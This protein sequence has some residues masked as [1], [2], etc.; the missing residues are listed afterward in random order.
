IPGKSYVFKLAKTNSEGRFFFSIAEGYN[1][2]NSTIQ[3]NGPQE[4]NTQYKIVLDNKALQIG[5][6]DLSAIKLDPNIRDWLEQRSVQM[7]IENAYFNIK[8]DSIMEQKP[9]TAF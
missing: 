9:S 7:Q 6:G 5:K 2:E 4:N 3:I 1:S 8:K